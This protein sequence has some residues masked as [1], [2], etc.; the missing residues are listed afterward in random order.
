MNKKTIFY[1]L[2]GIIVSMV[3]ISLIFI[4]I[5]S[6]KQELQGTD[7]KGEAELA[8]EKKEYEKTSDINVLETSI[9]EIRMSPNAKVIKKT[10]FE[11]CDH[12]IRLEEEIPNDLINGNENDVINYYKDWKVE[13]FS[14]TEIILYREEKKNCNEHYMVKEHYGVIGIYSI[15]ANG[16]EIFEEDT[17]ISTKYL[18]ETDIELLKKGVKIIGKTKLIEFLED[19]E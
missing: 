1:I 18:P 15:N 10:Y 9:T 11:I 5:K 7:I 13:K 3:I 4:I 12:L 2:I 8:E 14:P 6:T 17:E 16:E 19:Y